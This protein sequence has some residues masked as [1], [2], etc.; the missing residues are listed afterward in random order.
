[1]NVVLRLPRVAHWWLTL[2]AMLA[3]LA[4]LSGCGAPLTVRREPGY[5]KC[6]DRLLVVSHMTDVTYALGNKA[7]KH[8]RSRLA[9]MDVEYRVISVS[10][11]ATQTELDGYDRIANEL[12]PEAILKI[13]AVEITHDPA[14]GIRDLIIDALLEDT[15]TKR[16]VWRG[17]GRTLPNMKAYADKVI[18][19]LQADGLLTHRSAMR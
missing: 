5:A 12:R 1:M 17:R 18:A 7:D 2:V 4:M 11:V 6:I 13:T 14:G 3:L 15:A 8:F 19:Q 16:V 10:P 9:D